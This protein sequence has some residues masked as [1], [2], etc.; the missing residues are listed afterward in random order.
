MLT[1]GL[2]LLA[3]CG[4]DEEESTPSTTSEE[5]SQQESS[6]QNTTKAKTPSTPETAE[7]SSDTAA[8]KE[9]QDT[10][11][12]T[13]TQNKVHKKT[14]TISTENAS[15]L[16]KEYIERLN[17]TKKEID[18]MRENPTDYSDAGLQAAEDEHYVVWDDLLNEIYG[19]LKEQLSTEEMD[20][21]REAQRGWI[22]YRD[23]SAANSSQK[24]KGGTMEQLE[25]VMVM[26]K[27]TEERC[28]ELV[29]NHMK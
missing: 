5:Q 24:Y 25:Y 28:F 8:E 3:S 27:L 6:S 26:S 4:K 13:D 18:E 1:V 22:D 14:Q 2:V 15:S 7:E 29:E 21:L 23:N 11:E 17:D 16:K 9:N 12:N 10:T 20:K 19:V